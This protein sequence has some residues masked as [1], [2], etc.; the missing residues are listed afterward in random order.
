MILCNSFMGMGEF[1]DALQATPLAL[2]YAFSYDPT[3]RAST[4]QVGLRSA[5]FGLRSASLRL[6]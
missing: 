1:G 6:R 5:S 3:G 2:G 4:Q